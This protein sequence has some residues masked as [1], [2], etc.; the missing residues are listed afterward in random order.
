VPFPSGFV[1]RFASV[2]QNVPFSTP[3]V[4]QFNATI[5]NSLNSGW[6][7]L[8]P[9][10]LQATDAG[11]YQVQ[12]GIAVEILLSA[13]TINPKIEWEA[14]AWYNLTNVEVQGSASYAN[15][16]ILERLVANGVMLSQTTIVAACPGQVLRLL[17]NVFSSDKVDTFAALL[18]PVI[19]PLGALQPLVT[20][21]SAVSQVIQRLPIP[22]PVC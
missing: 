13:T 4:V 20:S 22:P 6:H 21:A 10:A 14:S 8:S 3:T 9:F 2:T 18:V 19:T 15:G 1:A 12:Y 7:V 5:V 16:Y 11:W 17:V